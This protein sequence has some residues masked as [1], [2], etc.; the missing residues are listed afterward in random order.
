MGP[1]FSNKLKMLHDRLTVEKIPH[2]Y[3][4]K[5]NLLI[6]PRQKADAPDMPENTFYIGSVS[7]KDD[8]WG[9]VFQVA[10][11]SI[12]EDDPKYSERN[13]R[14][15]LEEAKRLYTTNQPRLTDSP[16]APAI[17]W[18][19]DLTYKDNE[20]NRFGVLDGIIRFRGSVNDVYRVME[21]IGELPS[22]NFEEQ[23]PDDSSSPSEEISTQPT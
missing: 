12:K 5:A 19:V 9:I 23:K 13:T 7:A 16:N 3:D 14:Y 15:L 4:E 21:Y 10:I 2:Q 11:R 20:G 18:D 6:Y 17:Q 8:I 1:L 22:T